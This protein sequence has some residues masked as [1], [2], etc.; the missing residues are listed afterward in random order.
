VSEEK[1]S[2]WTAV[3]GAFRDA[4]DGSESASRYIECG[5]AGVMGEVDGDVGDRSWE[6]GKQWERCQWGENQAEG[7]IGPIL[8]A[9]LA[10][11]YPIR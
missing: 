2:H 6:E 10:L 11:P 3:R 8:V 4:S 9:T 5:F 7:S 1:L